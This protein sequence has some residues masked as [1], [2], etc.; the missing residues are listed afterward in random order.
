MKGPI[1]AAVAAA[2]VDDG[3]VAGATAAKAAVGDG[4]GLLPLETP[5]GADAATV[6]AIGAAVVKAVAWGE[7]AAL[8]PPLALP[9]VAEEESRFPEASPAA[10]VVAAAAAFVLTELKLGMRGMLRGADALRTR[11]EFMAF[12]PLA[13][14]AVAPADEV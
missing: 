10:G 4:N 13:A 3:V 14:G 5:V 6:K 7:V 9:L 1:A 11:V 8:L 2:G 12:M